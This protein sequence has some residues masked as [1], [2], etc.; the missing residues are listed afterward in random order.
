VNPVFPF[1]NTYARLPARFFAE[2]TP[3][4]VRA[5]RLLRLN[6]QLAAELSL[7]ESALRS[8]AG[9]AVLAGNR[10]PEGS[11][12]LAQAYAGH[13]FGGFV[14]QL[15]DGRAIL[16]GELQPES[17]MRVDV[18]LKGAGRT[19]FSRGGDGRAW[20]GPVLREYIVSE[21]MH[22]LGVPTTRAL[23]AV[24]TGE[25]VLRERRLPGAVLT[26]VARSHVRVGTFQ[27][28]AARRDEEGLRLL[29]EYARARHYPDV[30]GPLAFLDAVI[31]AE[32]QLVARWLGL[33]FIHGVMNTDNVHIAG[34][35]LDYGPCAF[36]DDYVPHK[37]FSSIDRGGRYAYDR[38]PDVMIWNLTQLATALLPLLREEGS[39]APAQ[40]LLEEA[41]Q[42]FRAAWLDVFRHKLGLAE[43]RPFDDVL[44]LDLLELMA[45]TREDFTRTFRGLAEADTRA[46][47][48]SAEDFGS[49]FVRWEGRLRQEGSTAAGIVE[50]LRAANPLVIPRNHLVERVIAAAVKGE[51]A[52]FHRLA[53]AVADP[54]RERDDIDDLLAPPRPEEE[55][56]ATFCGT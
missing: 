30:E 27:F 42:V 28:F 51:L 34:D 21:A 2:V 52:P 56:R 13:Q 6:V 50:R 25:E 46:H 26:R 31:R 40:S 36:L 9:V 54:F 47:L 3:T 55:V 33:G 15:G 53:D 23:A 12:P 22:G 32:A 44:V 45:T 49:W 41:P 38:Q 10:V 24:S 43:R 35:T 18:Q 19:P 11:V 16:L 20:L 1:D 48:S 17:G 7:D 14:P 37:V 4:P 5:P 39:V 8:E 29:F